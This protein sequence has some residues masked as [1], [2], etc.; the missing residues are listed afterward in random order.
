MFLAEGV[1]VAVDFSSGNWGQ[2]IADVTESSDYQ[3]CEIQVD[4]DPE[5]LVAYDYQTAEQFSVTQEVSTAA[6]NAT[7]KFHALQAVLS[8]P[9]ATQPGIDAATD[10][11]DDAVDM[12]ILTTGL[13]N[14]EEVTVSATAPAGV[15]GDLWV[16]TVDGK[17]V[18]LVFD[19]GWAAL[20]V[21]STVYSGQARFIPVRAGV[22]QG[23][24]AQLN[25]TTIR[26]VRF[27]LPRSAMDTR[28]HAGAIVTIVSAPFNGNLNGR[29]AKVNDDFQGSTT[30]TRTFHAT[31]DADS[32]DT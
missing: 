10:N 24:E 3:T 23:G 8:D 19:S 29:T 30:A 25:T 5:V 22:W 12:L 31:M 20:P 9:L 7:S 21:N 2:E 15:D 13:E 6:L 17:G 27:Q 1:A 28:I 18:V 32:E 26:A 16:R 14:V 11:Y 4:W